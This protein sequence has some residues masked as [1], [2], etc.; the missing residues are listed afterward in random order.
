MMLNEDVQVTE[1]AP[2][3]FAFLREMDGYDNE[4]I[5]KSLHP[6]NNKKSVFKAGESQGKSGSFFFFSQDEKFIIKTMTD[7]DFKAFMDL[8]RSYVRH[9]CRNRKSL[10]ARVYGIYSI[11]MGEQHP[12]KLVVMGHTIQYKN[13]DLI[14]HTYDLKGSMV[15]RLVKGRTKPTAPVKDKNLLQDVQF[16][17]EIFLNFSPKDQKILNAQIA[18]DVELLREFNLMDY[19][20]LLCVEK[21]EPG[22]KYVKSKEPH[23]ARHIYVGAGGTFVYHISVIDYLQDFNIDKKFENVFK[24]LKDRKNKLLISAVHPDDYA[25]RFT[26]WM[27]ENVFLD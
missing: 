14:R 21:V 8:F 25:T 9:V 17:K 16:D 1:Y 18:K 23:R 12:V 15:N 5:K 11:Q 13:K 27:T 2:D 26:R 6:D 4:S 7:S 24:S 19:S 10:L 3:V 22:T 20:L